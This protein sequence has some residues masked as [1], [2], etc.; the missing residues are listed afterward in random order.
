MD[1]SDLFDGSVQIPQRLS[2][3]TLQD[4][5]AEQPSYISK[6]LF[7]QQPV[8]HETILINSDLRPASVLEELQGQ[9]YLC[10]RRALLST[11]P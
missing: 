7:P 3:P 10:L 6:T 2:D 1:V 4:L 11:L 5:T 9:D 8:V